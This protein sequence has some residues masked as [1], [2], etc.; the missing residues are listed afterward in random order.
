MKQVVLVQM[1]RLHLVC[2]IDFT[3]LITKKTKKTCMYMIIESV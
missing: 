2:W 3:I 1:K